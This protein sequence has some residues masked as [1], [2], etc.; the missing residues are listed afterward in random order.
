MTSKTQPHNDDLTWK[1]IDIFAA[2]YGG[3]RLQTHP[4]YL[5]WK[6]EQPSPH[7]KDAISL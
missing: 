4:E 5:R 3:H 6:T 1:Q 7:D 2:K